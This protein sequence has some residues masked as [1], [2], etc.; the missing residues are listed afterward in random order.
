M[1]NEK[2]DVVF[3][4]MQLGGTKS[5]IFDLTIPFGQTHLHFLVPKPKLRTSFWAPVTP[6]T[7]LVW[8]L[9]I[10]MLII[11]SLLVYTK[12]RL[13]STGVSKSNITKFVDLTLFTT[14][15]LLVS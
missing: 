14:F 15:F 4:K 7:P 6:F 11:Q 1:E 5:V 2:P 8:I 10:V 13:F 9:I 12:A 3:T